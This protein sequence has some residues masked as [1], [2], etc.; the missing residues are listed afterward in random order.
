MSTPP[1]RGVALFSAV[2]EL[3]AS[4]RAAYLAEACA[5]ELLESCEDSLVGQALAGGRLGDAEI[6]HFGRSG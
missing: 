6:N 1:N 5:D 3:P 4:E 2:L